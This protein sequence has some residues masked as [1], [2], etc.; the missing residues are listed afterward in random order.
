[1]IMCLWST[2][3][4]MTTDRAMAAGAQTPPKPLVE[5]AHGRI[6]PEKALTAAGKTNCQIINY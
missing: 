2:K 1:M 5:K 6:N 4:V 3:A